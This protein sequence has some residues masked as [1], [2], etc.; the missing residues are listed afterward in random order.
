MNDFDIFEAYKV[1][2]K[3]DQK[4]GHSL[5]FLLIRIH[6]GVTKEIGDLLRSIQLHQWAH[7]E[8]L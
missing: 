4:K 7:L 5:G 8:A 2:I 1:I 6:T 3:N